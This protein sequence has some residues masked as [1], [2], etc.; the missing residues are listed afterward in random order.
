ME[1][2][3]KTLELSGLLPDFSSFPNVDTPDGLSAVFVVVLMTFFCAFV[4]YSA[5]RFWQARERISW[6]IEL[7]SLETG[8]TVFQNRNDLLEKVGKRGGIESHL[9]SEFD[10]TLIEV[11]EGDQHRVCNVYDADHFF[12][13]TSMAPGITENRLIA[14]APGLLTAI[15]VIG[16]FVGL[17]LGLSGLNIGNDVAVDEMKEGLAYVISGAKIAFMTSVWG[18]FLSFLFNFMEKSLE[19]QLRNQ[20]GLLQ[21]RIDEIFHRLTAEMQ[22]KRIADDG[23]ESREALQGL[24][25]K[26]GIKMQES[27]LE[28]TAGIQQGLEQS[29]QNV[30]GPAM[31]RLVNDASDGSQRALEQ[32]I[33]T[34]MDKFGQQG[35]E[36]RES[37]SLASREVRDA[38]D[39]MSTVLNSFVNNLNQNQQ[40]STEREQELIRHI[41]D[42]VDALVERTVEHHKQSSQVAEEQLQNFGELFE[43]QT[44]TSVSLQKGLIQNF[45]EQIDDMA[46]HNR[47][48]QKIQSD[49]ENALALQFENTITDIKIAMQNQIEATQNVL[50]DAQKLHV[51][52]VK[53]SESLQN[54]AFSIHDASKEISKSANFLKDFGITLQQTSSKLSN[55]V[56]A[57]S[58]STVN[59]A[60]EN[61]KISETMSFMRDDIR[62]SITTIERTVSNLD[63]LVRIANSTFKELEQ[64]Q[65]SYLATLKE[66]IEELAKNGTNLLRDYAEQA[67]GQTKEHLKIWAQ[68]ANDYAAQMNDAVRAL[69]SVVDE[70]E[71]KVTC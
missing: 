37:M 69:S 7:L 68:S 53:N 6:L 60:S 3:V 48:H 19:G 51:D 35:A 62:S 2:M 9:W 45:K 54:L 33:G 61:L 65:N 21:V 43:K 18:V 57:A 12:N 27:L 13:A 4:F 25:E 52:F 63:Q 39:S 64:H 56:L 32:L 42:Q 17:Q 24:A 38:V 10:E 55:S 71:N 29:L 15:G 14:A 49:R 22:L 16:T 47:Q 70:I 46:D 66:N 58:E 36:Q 40:A 30:L 44:R 1:S 20:I 41:S 26:I 34:F 28:A 31:D 11:V 23:N 67:N 8:N 50:S 59:L 5:L